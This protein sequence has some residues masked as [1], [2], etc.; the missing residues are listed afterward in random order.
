MFEMLVFL[1]YL[2]I[3]TCVKLRIYFYGDDLFY[4]K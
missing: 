1:D 2:A 3:L 4:S